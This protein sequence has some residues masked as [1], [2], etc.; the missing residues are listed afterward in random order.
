METFERFFKSGSF[1]SNSR[2][3][4]KLRDNRNE[5]IDNSIDSD[6][7]NNDI[8]SLD[9]NN[10]NTI[11]SSDVLKASIDETIDPTDVEDID[12]DESSVWIEVLDEESGLSYYWNTE[13]NETTSLGDP[14]PEIY[15][16]EFDAK[17]DDNVNKKRERK[18]KKKNEKKG[19][20]IIEES[21]EI[22]LQD[23]QST[24]QRD[25]EIPNID[26]ISNNENVV[27]TID[28]KVIDEII[29]EAKSLNIVTIIDNEINI[30]EDL[31]N[32]NDDISICNVMNDES[33]NKM[34]EVVD[35]IKCDTTI[36]SIID[37]ETSIEVIQTINTSE[38]PIIESI[39]N[40]GK[41]NTLKKDL[42]KINDN[43]TKLSTDTNIKSR[44]KNSIKSNSIKI[45]PIKQKSIKSNNDN[46]DKERKRGFTT[47]FVDMFKS[48]V[49]NSM[50]TCVKDNKFDKSIEIE[51]INNDE[52]VISD[53]ISKNVDKQQEVETK[54]EDDNEDDVIIEGMAS[55]PPLLEYSEFDVPSDVIMSP[56]VKVTIE[57]CKICTLPTGTCKH[58]LNETVDNN[59]TTISSLIENKEKGKI[60]YPSMKKSSIKVD[61]DYIDFTIDE[62]ALLINWNNDQLKI[63][64][65]LLTVI[66]SSFDLNDEKAANKS[67]SDKT[68]D[69]LIKEL[70]NTIQDKFLANSYDDI[71]QAAITFRHILRQDKL[72]INLENDLKLKGRLCNYPIISS[73]RNQN[74]SSNAT[75]PIQKRSKNIIGHSTCLTYIPK[76]SL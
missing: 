4:L 41:N 45:T 11:I 62:E 35:V 36:S 74:R 55:Y 2:T 72:K 50:E 44:R 34:I 16:L 32:R 53:T 10:T 29:R 48:V 3:R 12:N 30:Q 6:N 70:N 25:N 7:N 8:K 54:D 38:T 67:I 1:K 46:K 65:D 64:K 40:N 63:K 24:D 61:D 60:S 58:T 49:G 9:I 27:D 13:T 59:N 28:N 26:T 18:K 51:S 52:I 73:P 37:T 19:L 21:S 57:R 42:K 69:I 33:N 14:K 31:S 71:R 5:L 23:F 17:D 43:D 75:S 68:N 20:E 66:V 22:Q 76:T 39:N 56:K 15:S 47:F